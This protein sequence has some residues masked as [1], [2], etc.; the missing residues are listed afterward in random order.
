MTNAR[1][2]KKMKPD[3]KMLKLTRMAILFLKLS[4][5]A[6]NTALKNIKDDTIINFFEGVKKYYGN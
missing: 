5:E 2:E 3:K 6:Q 4:E 1:K